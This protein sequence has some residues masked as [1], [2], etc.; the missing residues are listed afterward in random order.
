MI[1]STTSAAPGED[2]EAAGAAHL[3]HQ[4]GPGAAAHPRLE[5]RILDA[6]QITKRGTQD[7]DRNS[8]PVFIGLA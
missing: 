1:A 3:T 4:L 5:D 2:A 6:Q 7:H 8:S